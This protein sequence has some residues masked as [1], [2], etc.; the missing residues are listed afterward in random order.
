M[1]VLK[2]LENKI[3]LAAI[4]STVSIVSSAVVSI[5]SFIIARGEVA[6]AHKNIYVLDGNLP[7]LV[8]QTDMEVTNAIEAKADN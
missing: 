4:L 2:N 5:F 3:K 6:D 7:V 8:H 1:S